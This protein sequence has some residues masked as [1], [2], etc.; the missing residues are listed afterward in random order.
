MRAIPAL[1]RQPQEGG[2]EASVSSSKRGGWGGCR[3][4]NNTYP[5]NPNDSFICITLW[6]VLGWNIYILLFSKFPVAWCCVTGNRCL[7]PSC[8]RWCRWLWRIFHYYWCLVQ[9]R[10][11]SM[12]WKHKAHDF[13]PVHAL[14][15]SHTLRCIHGPPHKKKICMTAIESSSSS[16][17]WLHRKNNS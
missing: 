12:K 3:G 11:K 17:P 1:Q 10:L 4:Q 5:E 13:T 2:G 8:R 16:C 7:I 9:K 15:S 14:S 6:S